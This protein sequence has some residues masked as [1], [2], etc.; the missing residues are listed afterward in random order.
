MIKAVKLVTSVVICLAA[1]L[2]GTAATMPS[3]PTWYAG[4]NKPFFNPPAW[5]FAPVW[6]VLYI[7]MGISAYLVW[8]SVAEKED[9][10]AALSMFAVQLLANSLWSIIFFGMHS[11]FWSVIEIIVLW[12]AILMTIR[13][14]YGISRTASYLMVPYIL[15]VSFAA[16]LNVSILML[17]R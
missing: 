12:S 6:T 3:I 13:Y 11:L 9:I 7:L 10:K 17:N 8:E 4:L 14:F 15:W 1:G 2:I 5:I 16:V